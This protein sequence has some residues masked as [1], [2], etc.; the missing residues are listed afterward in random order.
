MNML[1]NFI[2]KILSTFNYRIISNNYPTDFTEKDIKIIKFVN[3][4][5]MTSPERIKC[6][7]DAT[8]YIVKNKIVGTFVE[9]GVWRGG[10]VMA[11]MLMLKKLKVNNTKFYLFDTFDGMSEPSNFDRDYSKNK[12]KDLLQYNTKDKNNKI[13][14]YS[15]IE[16]VKKNIFKTKY[17]IKNIKFIK[18]KVEVTLKYYAPKKIALLRLDTD[19]YQ[20][21]K[22]E[23]EILFPRLVKGGVLIIDDY[24]YWKGCK[25]AVDE[26]F[27]KKNTYFQHRIDETGII[28]IKK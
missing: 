26:Y 19:W 7:I 10:S 16:E 24:G 2:K 12:G 17:P 15:P 20:S 5:T 25:K 4:Y 13:W 23:L 21:T 8:K 28:L 6:L 9:C 14:C 22:Y 11:A 3:N 27:L 1:K 18:G